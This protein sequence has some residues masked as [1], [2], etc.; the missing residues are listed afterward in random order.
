MA[1]FRPVSI[2]IK[3]GKY[4][5]I[6]SVQDAAEL[7]LSWPQGRKRLAAMAECL[8]ALEGPG[9]PEK[10]RQCFIAAAEEAGVFVREVEFP[11]PRSKDE[12]HAKP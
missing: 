12:R 7:V 8:A 1:D 9:L 3:P 2:E 10:V 6:S 5:T 4:R 11:F